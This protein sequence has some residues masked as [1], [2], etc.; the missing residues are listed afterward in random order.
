[1]S[2]RVPLKLVVIAA[3]AAG[4]QALLAQTLLIREELLLYGGNEVAIGAFLGLWLLGIAAGALGVRRF[5]AG[6]G[7]W[8]VPLLL[9]QGVLPLLATALAGLARDLAGIPPYEPFP[10]ALLLL[11]SVPVAVPVSLTTGALVPALAARARE[12]G[13]SVT[14]IY[15]AEALGSLV[16]GVGATAALAAGAEP[17]AALLGC[18]AIGTVGA[19]ALLRRA[20]RPLALALTAALLLAAPL[21]GPRLGDRL[22]A[23]QLQSV[24]PD[25]ALLDHRETASASLMLAQLRRQQVLLI[26]GQVIAAF[27]DPVRVERAAGVLAAVT[28]GP[29]S[30]LVVGTQ[31][32]DL[33][34]GLLALAALEQVVWVLPDPGIRDFALRHLPGLAGDARLEVVVGDPIRRAGELEQRGPF[35]A[36]W[37]LVDTP[38]RRSDDR[39]VTRETLGTLAALLTPNG[40]MAVPVRS[41]ENYVGPRLRL[42]VGTV[43]AGVARALD[44]VRLIPGED[45]LVLGARRAEQLDFQPARLQ[46]LYAGMRPRTPRLS[47][48]G[49]A[50]LLEARRLERA[51]SLVRSL[52]RDPRNRPSDLDRPLALFHNLLVRAEQESTELTRLLEAL[53]HRAGALWVPLA[54]LGL[55]GVGGVLVRRQPTDSS[56]AAALGVLAAGGA[57]GMGLDLLL[58]HLYQGRFGTLYLEVGWLFGLWMGGL[59]LGGVAGRRL[60]T[61]RG[62]YAAG[63]VALAGLAALAAALALAGSAALPARLAGALAF[64]LAGA[65]SG[66]LIPV[67]EALLAGGGIVGARAGVGIEA[68]DHLGGAA[69]ALGLGVLGIP[70]LGLAQVAWWVVGLAA[71]GAAAL[72]ASLLRNRGLLPAALER[73][74]TQAASFESFPYRRTALL[75]FA[76]AAAAWIGHLVVHRIL[77]GPRVHLDAQE[78]TDAGLAPPWRQL[79]APVVH[80][81]GVDR[82]LALASQAAAARVQGYGGPLNLLVATDHEGRLRHLAFLE[83]RETPSYVETA[84]AFFAALKGKSLLEPFRVR[85]RTPGVQ[86]GAEPPAAGGR[87]QQVDAITGATVTSRAV[88]RA[89]EETGQRLAQPVFDRGYAGAPSGLRPGDPRFLYLAASLLLLLPVFL[90]G[91]RRLR[92]IWLLLHVTVGGVWL[93]VQFSTVQVLSWLRLEPGLSLSTWTGLL[94]VAA[95]LAALV[96]PLYCGYLCPAGAAQELLSHLGLSRRMPPEVDRPARFVKYLLL[97]ALVVAA[98]GLESETVLRLDLLREVWA[99]HRT[100]LGVFSIAVVAAG[101]LL[102]VRFG[103]RYLCPTGA[104]LN[105]LSKL[106]P[107][108]RFLPDKDYSACDLGVRGRPD[109][110]CLQCNRCLVGERAPPA[111]PWRVEA[112]RAALLGTLLLLAIAALPLGAPGDAT[113]TVE[114][115]IRPVDTALIKM[116]I[117]AGRLS[118][119][120]AEYWHV[121][122][123]GSSGASPDQR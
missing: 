44:Q 115:R 106:A 25:A 80:Y 101:C 39:F 86:R 88:A 112:F 35:D 40:V 51:D 109:V 8:A 65:L 24:L 50:S 45:G 64:P 7:R 114:P 19:S 117:S 30:L 73:R 20:A 18:A 74:L 6:A 48:E 85:A 33:L 1:V 26:D 91:G 2:N 123:P 118:D 119:T 76:L 79:D 46:R 38:M 68:A 69:C 102:T 47:Q 87:A 59:A 82:D 95:P 61:R 53:R 113:P 37:L 27:P 98:L 78:L 70:I 99:E 42:A 54:V 31:A 116:K 58:L 93:G 60:S 121:V 100:A 67:A 16:G 71:F 96:G 3:F 110:D 4:A 10:L 36:V 104:F 62:P 34:P 43:V 12:A 77:L 94:L 21:A 57:I 11:W 41:A 89:L 52:L 72:A 83:H 105:L 49:F 92:R 14:H 29:A 22:R 17:A 107:L 108:S 56:R 32:A 66:A 5:A 13:G 90:R 9:I 111:P 75:L 122:R 120:R 23:R 55:F 63:L 15:V 28:G 97:T 103:C 81:R 84:D